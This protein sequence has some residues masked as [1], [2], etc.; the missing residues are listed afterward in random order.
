MHDEEYTIREALQ[1]GAK[2]YIMKNSGMNDLFLAIERISNGEKYFSQDV[3]TK[4]I[5]TSINA[6]KK[7]GNKS[8]EQ[9]DEILSNREVEILKMY[10]QEKS[11]EEIAKKL[12]LSK[13][14][15]EKHKYNIMVK[16]GIKTHL[17]LAKYALKLD[18][19]RI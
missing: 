14:T 11:T 12:K 7:K 15:I 18:G 19:I 2:G 8:K 5:D 16:L 9:I 13:R 3:A 6:N 10:S 4:L 17:G 1:A